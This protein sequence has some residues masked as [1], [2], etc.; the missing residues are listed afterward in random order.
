MMHQPVLLKEVLAAFNPQP[1][2]TYIDATVNGGG[3]ARAIAERVG[4]KGRVI[5]LDWDCD[6]IQEAE[7]RSKEIGIK[8]IEFVCENYVNLQSVARKYNVDEVSGILFDLGF[9]SYHLEKARRGFSFLRD[10][11]LDMR[12]HATQPLTASEIVNQ[13]PAETIEDVLREYGEE[14]FA[15]QITAGII[16]A[17]R[18]QKI[19]TTGALVRIISKSVPRGY[20]KGRRNP[21][22]KTFQALRIVVNRELENLMKALEESIALVSSGGKIIVISFHS[23]EDRIVKICFQKNAHDGLLRLITKKP[24]LSSRQEKVFNV[25]ARSAK[26]RA[27]QKV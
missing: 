21:A 14:R 11:P 25:R 26:L 7:T 2:Q 24:I 1:G 13:W 15:R 3:H 6:L 10:E 27:A 22:T 16:R 9:S 18:D 19:Y 20:V 5:G 4:P 12:Y 8:N 17:R 23:L